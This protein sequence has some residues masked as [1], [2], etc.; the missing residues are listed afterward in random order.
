MSHISLY[1]MTEKVKTVIE[2]YFL[3]PILNL[4]DTLVGHPS[5]PTSRV[6]LSCLALCPKL[7]ISFGS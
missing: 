3:Y 1:H 5:D 4:A 7:K 2:F 6:E